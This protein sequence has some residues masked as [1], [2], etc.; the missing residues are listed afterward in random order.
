[1]VEL[2]EVQEGLCGLVVCSFKA[3]KASQKNTTTHQYWY[4]RNQ[5][6][7]KNQ[8]DILVAT[9]DPEVQNQ[10]RVKSSLCLLGDPITHNCTLG[11]FEPQRQESGI[12]YLQ[13]NKKGPKSSLALHVTGTPGAPMQCWSRVHGPLRANLRGPW[14]HLFLS[15]AQ[16]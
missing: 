14:T 5:S 6:D 1:M 3:T 4:R 9:S 12:Y 8:G 11:I 15:P 13:L 16:H 10:I 2:V 7:P